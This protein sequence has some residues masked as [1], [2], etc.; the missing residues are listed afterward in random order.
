MSKFY[1]KYRLYNVGEERWSEE[2]SEIY[3]ASDIYNA[4]A[5]LQFDCVEYLKVEILDIK[6]V[7]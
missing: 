4:C 5:N 7:L 6:R 2:Q 1:I 3:A